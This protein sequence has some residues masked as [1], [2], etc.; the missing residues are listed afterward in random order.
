MCGEEVAAE[1][2]RCDH[3]GTA[4]EEVELE[5]PAPLPTQAQDPAAVA[6]RG[7]DSMRRLFAHT[8]G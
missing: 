2:L 7:L 1:A 5:A 4:F 8:E 3:C 6:T